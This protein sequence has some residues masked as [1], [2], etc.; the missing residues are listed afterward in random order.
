MSAFTEI[1]DE[2]M[3]S[4]EKNLIQDDSRSQKLTRSMFN[5]KIT[6]NHNPIQLSHYST[7]HT[8]MI[9]NKNKLDH[10]LHQHGSFK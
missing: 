3:S 1:L 4:V 2:Q 5:N 7:S 9:N 10:S 8:I 6:L